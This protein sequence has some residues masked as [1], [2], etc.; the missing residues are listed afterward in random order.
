M[1]GNQRERN[2]ELAHGG[3]VSRQGDIVTLGDGNQWW[4]NGS[5]QAR[6]E[7][8]SLIAVDARRPMRIGT[9]R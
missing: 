8:D 2:E 7:A 4:L 5:I 3:L 9:R 6:N 1:T